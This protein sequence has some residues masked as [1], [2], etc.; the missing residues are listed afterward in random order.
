MTMSITAF[1]LGRMNRLRVDRLVSIGAYLDAGDQDILLPLRYLPEGVC[2]DDELD[3]FVY[4]D[5]EGR[6]IATTLKPKVQVGEVAYLKVE[7]VSPVGAFM[8]WGIHRD[9]FVPFAEQAQPMVEGKKYAVA[10]YIDVLSAKVQASSKIYKHVGNVIP[11]YAPGAMVRALV[12]ERSEIGLRCVVDHKHWGMLYLDELPAPLPV[13]AEVK[14]YVVRIREDDKIDLS[15]RPVGYVKIES[16]SDRLLELIKQN[17]GSLP[18]GDKSDP[19]EIERLTGLSKK[20]FKM[21]AGML[22]KQRLIRIG[23]YSLEM[24]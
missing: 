16:E 1:K 15:I 20:S 18:L 7:S 14:S 5:N 17:G 21:A 2:E 12:V 9:L 10:V 23:K 22:F 19:K 24:T 8:E 11:D 13:G 6:L 4:H 3:A